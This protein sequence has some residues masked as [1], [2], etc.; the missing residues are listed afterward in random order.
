MIQKCVKAHGSNSRCMILATILL[1]AVAGAATAQT[2]GGST[3]VG[4]VKDSSGALIPNAKI[5]VINTGTSFHSE[6]ETSAEGN[7]Y[8]PYLNPGTAETPH[9]SAR[10]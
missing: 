9:G 4:T 6:G 8:I 7:Y 2:G 5:T 1:A 10:P 3:L